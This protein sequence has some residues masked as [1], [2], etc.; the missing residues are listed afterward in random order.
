MTIVTPTDPA[1]EGDRP[2]LIRESERLFLADLLAAPDGVAALTAAP[3]PYDKKPFPDG[4]KWRAGIPRAVA[5]RGIVV[6]VTVADAAGFTPA[7]R[8]TRKRTRIQLYRLIDRPAAERLANELAASTP[9]RPA[10]RTL[11][12]SLDLPAD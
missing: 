7:E 4:G 6:P 2:R 11:F 10:E 1:G 3:P 12:D 5:R 9:T 8:P